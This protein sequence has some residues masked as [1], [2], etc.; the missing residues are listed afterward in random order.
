[1][2]LAGFDLT[3]GRLLT[4][5]F[6]GLTYGLL[7]VG[8]VLVYR[9]SRFINFASAAVGVFGASVLGVLVAKAGLPYWLAFPLAVIAG[10]LI[11]GGIELGFVRRI[12][13]APRV[14]GTV[15]TLG[16]SQFLILAGL[17][18]NKDNAS[19]RLYPKPPFLPSFKLFGADVN[20]SYSGVIILTPI[21]LVVLVLFL[22]KTRY[23]L[24]IRAS[25]DNPDAASLAG[26]KAS[27]MVSLSWIIAGALAAF[28]TTLIYPTNPLPDQSSLGPTLLI[29]ALVGAVIG[30]FQNLVVAFLA[31]AGI[32]IVDTILRSNSSD[33]WATGISDLALAVIVFVALLLQPRL[34]TRRDEDKGEWQRLLPPALPAAYQKVVAIRGLVPVT[35]LLA[36]G[37]AVYLG[38]N[39]TNSFA[40]VLTAVVGGSLIGLSVI[41]VTGIAGQ[42]SLG[43]AAFAAVAGAVA[44]K[45]TFQSGN[46]WLGLVAGLIAAGFIAVLIGIPAL[47]LR[48]LALAVS[49]LAFSFATTA[50]LLRQ[51][52]LLGATASGVQVYKP[53]GIPGLDLTLAKD[54]YLF[55]LL[56]LVVGVVITWNIRRTGFG[57]VMRALRDNE[58][59]ARALTVAASKRKLET[60][61]VSGVVAGLGGVV[62]AFIGST[63]DQTRFAKAGSIDVVNQTVLGGLGTIFGPVAGSL[64]YLVPPAKGWLG[65]FGPSLLA[66][67][68]VIIVVAFPRGIVGAFVVLRNKIADV[69]A[70][71]SGIDVEAARLEGQGGPTDRAISTV[72]LQTLVAAR[73]TPP[74]PPSGRIILQVSGMS[75][76]FGG[77]KAV[78]NVNLEVREGE[79]L[80]IIGPNGAGKTTLFEMV[81]GF[82]APD[83]GT[84]VFEGQDLT[85]LTPEKR[86]RLGVVRSFQAARLFPT[87][88]VLETV[89]V[90]QE[91]IAPTSLWKSVL[92]ITGPDKKK[93]AKAREL[94][95][96]MGLTSMINKPVGELS[97]GTRRM[98]EIT[99]MLALEPRVLLLDEPAGGIAQSEGNAL[100]ELLHSVRRDLGVTIVIIEHDLPLLFRLADRCIAMELGGVIATGTPDEVKN[101]PD[102][103][104]SYLGADAV[105]VERSGPFAGAA[106][107]APVA[108]VAT[109]ALLEPGQVAPPAYA[110]PAYEAPAPVAYAPP[111]PAAPP[112]YEA[113]APAAPPAYAPPAPAA[114]PVY[115]APAP[116]AYEPPAPAAP[117]AYAP[118][119]PA[120][121]PA[122]APPAPAAPPVYEAPAPVAYEPPAPAA[123]PAYAPRLRLL[124]R[125]TRPRHRWPTS[126]R[127]PRLRRRTHRRLRLLRR[128]TRPRHRWPT[129]PR[130]RR[131][132][133]RTHLRLRQPRRRAPAS[134]LRRSTRRPHRLPTRLRLTSL[135]RR[136]RPALRCRSSTHLRHRQ[137]RRST[138]RPHRSLTSPRHPRPR[139]RTHRRLRQHLR[140]T[141]RRRSTRTTRSASD[142]PE[143]PAAP[144]RG[145]P[146]CPDVGTASARVSARTHH[147][148]LTPGPTSPRRSAPSLS[149][150]TVSEG[151]GGARRGHGSPMHPDL[152]RV[153]AT[154]QNLFTTAQALAAGYPKAEVRLRQRRGEWVALRRGVMAPQQV[155]A[156]AEERASGLTLLRA[157]A[158]LLSLSC[159]GWASHRTA[160]SAHGLPLL[161]PQ[162]VPV[163]LTVERQ[164]RRR[165]PGVELHTAR[166]PVSHRAVVDG[167][168]LTSVARTLSDLARSE[169]VGTAVVA[170]DA[171]IR[172]GSCTVGD[173]LAVIHDCPTWRGIAR[174]KRMLDLVD[175][176]SESPGES[177]SRLAFRSA[178]LPMPDLQG[179]LVLEGRRVRVDFLWPA[180]RLVGEFDGR[181]KYGETDALWQ[182][183]QRE[184]LIRRAGFSVVRWVW[185]DLQPDPERCLRRV[186]AALASASAR[187]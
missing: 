165:V 119:A 132:R 76:N 107:A 185:S 45:L 103:V 176:R 122:Y 81:A 48:G 14:L 29:Y 34:S 164:H 126:L 99:C 155:V 25:S 10:G 56:F 28:S 124:R 138:R 40:T 51:E 144:P 168:P 131:L 135:R 80:G 179:E 26:V 21:V 114:P 50:W 73:A 82:T 141:H 53:S 95:E 35:L 158:A 66:L 157:A 140:P 63:L 15:V 170:A 136:T 38:L 4:G 128:S 91:R 150:V 161:G 101:H 156:A 52:F 77:V 184:D 104:R 30:R 59:A 147:D 177:L 105:A 89:M 182:E 154:Q 2:N 55:S 121:P 17:L 32:G 120:A 19:P 106:A 174:T 139:P 108:A 171:A 130:L 162:A 123:P 36:G 75:K 70:G 102:V 13:N 109:T 118:P 71:A 173:L 7:A 8:L 111:A 153:A 5:V 134:Q 146:H 41:I 24:A 9:A 87:M 22:K 58:D 115:E 116:V 27:R 113:P 33:A 88:S 86:A 137:L 180:Q 57:R 20:A 160:A 11:S 62:I 79:I 74:A 37:Y 90:A 186:R 49:T 6:T 67:L 85:S 68:A 110:P 98:V 16:L 42:L 44:V 92:G 133:R 96:V 43:Q 61:A 23:G 12:S 127:L 152:L 18:V 125:S 167:L 97:T 148:T 187:G 83:G 60:F 47:R 175:G 78:Q 169:S 178:E 142:P 3:F 112:V 54:Y 183:K 65:E 31:S 163:V 94:I 181:T 129:S 84:T 172:G 159:E 93:E 166:T 69:I 145:L 72:H 143:A 39:T 117:P 151:M 149:P 64:Y 100:V 1:M 46:Y